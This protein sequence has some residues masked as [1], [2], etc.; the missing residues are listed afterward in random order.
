MKPRRAVA[1][2]LEA[3][4]PVPGFIAGGIALLLTVALLIA[5][6]RL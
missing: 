2:S 5:A 1:E 4:S 3:E 6:A